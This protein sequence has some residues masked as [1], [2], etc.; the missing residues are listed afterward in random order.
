MSSEWE[1]LSLFQ[2]AFSSWIDSDVQRWRLATIELLF[3]WI[4]REGVTVQQLIVLAVAPLL[5]GNVRQYSWLSGF[6]VTFI[7][8]AS[9]SWYSLEMPTGRELVA[10]C[11]CWGS[12]CALPTSPSWLVPLYRGLAEDL[13]YG[14]WIEECCSHRVVFLAQEII[15]SGQW[16]FCWSKTFW[17]NMHCSKLWLDFFFFFILSKSC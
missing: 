14:G 7:V 15:Y 1:Q 10:S 17:K 3:S 2:G 16:E 12:L 11:R 4:C 8:D 5:I 9:W 13:Q 6:A